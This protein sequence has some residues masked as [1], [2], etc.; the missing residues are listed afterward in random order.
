[1]TAPARLY[2]PKQMAR[3]SKFYSDLYAL[4]EEFEG[5]EIGE[6]PDDDHP[7]YIFAMD[8]VIR[9]KDGYTVG[10]IGLD[11]FPYFE[12]TDENYGEK[13]AS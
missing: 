8:I 1:M 4:I 10:R 9:H 2:D 7:L 13:S 5:G 11:D 12:I 6:F 3:I